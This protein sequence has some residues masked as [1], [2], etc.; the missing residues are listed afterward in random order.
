MERRGSDEA[1]GGSVDRGKEWRKRSSDLKSKRERGER[2]RARRKGERERRD[3]ER[4]R[5][6]TE[7]ERE[8]KTR[9]LKQ[10]RYRSR[11]W[12]NDH[13]AFSSQQ[14]AIPDETG[15]RGHGYFKTL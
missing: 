2:E 1:A 10:E 5:K 8:D 13:K 7:Q 9:I 4:K 15:Y 6:E 14:K 12:Q 3:R 11:C